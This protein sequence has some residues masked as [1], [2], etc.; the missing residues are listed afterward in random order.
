M[1]NNPIISTALISPL[2]FTMIWVHPI[3]FLSYN[4]TKFFHIIIFLYMCD[5]RIIS[6]VSDPRELLIW[7]IYWH[8]VKLMIKYHLL[9]WKMKFTWWIDQDIFFMLQI[10]NKWLL[11]T[12]S[13]VK[14]NK[15]QMKWTSLLELQ[16][17]KYDDALATL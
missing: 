16:A 14:W 17:H 7:K 13:L 2:N 6:T 11:S 10:N 5:F 4:N 8:M 3:N 9:S 15:N 12:Y 1:K